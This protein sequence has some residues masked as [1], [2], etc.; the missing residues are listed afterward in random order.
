M[1]SIPHPSFGL[2]RL[3]EY[4]VLFAFL[5]ACYVSIA[6]FSEYSIVSASAFKSAYFA[7]P[8]LIF[9]ILLSVYTHSWVFIRDAWKRRN[10][11][12]CSWL[13]GAGYA[14]FYMFV[15]NAL[16]APD[17]GVTIPAEL[18]QGYLIPFAAYGPMTVWP[19]VEFYSPTMNLVGY[20]SLG[21]VLLFASFGLL[22]AFAAAL[23]MRNIDLRSMRRRSLTPFGGV[24]LAS[25]STNA[26]CCCSPVIYPVVAILFGGAVPGVIAESLVNPES[27][28]SN[29]FVLATLACLVASVILLT[30][31]CQVTIREKQ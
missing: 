23:L 25:L 19:D 7:F 2:S 3:T 28:L 12:W 4:L 14:L 13:A 1:H 26:C 5:Y 15:T 17:A 8:I 6:Q 27:P 22:T 31:Q 29:L 9:S 20:L 18:S 11:R 10:W 24:I 16:S 30:R 21:N